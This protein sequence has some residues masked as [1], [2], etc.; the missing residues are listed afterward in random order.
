MISGGHRKRPFTIASTGR[1][2]KQLFSGFLA[3]VEA[4]ERHRT[5]GTQETE[6]T[7]ECGREGGGVEMAFVPEGQCDRSLP[8]SAWE[9]APQKSRPVGYGLI[10]ADVRSTIR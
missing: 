5:E 2:W 1:I 10:L 3:C 7:E 9:C 8:R 6:D 4:G